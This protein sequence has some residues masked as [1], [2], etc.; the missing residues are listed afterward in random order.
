MVPLRCHILSRLYLG[1]SKLPVALRQDG[2]FF[3]SQ[4][5]VARRCNIY[6]SAKDVDIRC[7]K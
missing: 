1:F 6:N 3:S 7:Y 5:V 2:A 4:T